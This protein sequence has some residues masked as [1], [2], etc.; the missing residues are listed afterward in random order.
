M[1]TKKTK[2]YRLSDLTRQ[3]IEQ[4]AE[5]W[6]TSLTET[7]TLIVDRAYQEATKPQK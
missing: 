7:I 6:G 3:Q 1:T 5:L 2:S 4:L